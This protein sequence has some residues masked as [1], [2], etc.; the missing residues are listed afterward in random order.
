MM[1]QLENLNRLS[2]INTDQD[3]KSLS[4]AIFPGTHCPLFGVALTAAYVKNMTMIIVGTSE[5]TYYTKNFAYHRQ[6]GEDSVYSLVLNDNEIVFGGHD[7]V[8]EAVREIIAI[9]EPDAVMVV[10]TCVPELIGENY[11]SIQYVLQEEQDI[12]I[13]IVHTEHYKCNSHI[14]GMSRALKAL[15][16]AMEQPTERTGVNLLGHRQANVEQTELV[17]LLKKQNIE[18]KTVIPSKCTIQEIKQA[19]NVQLNIVTDMVALP[20]A[21]EMKAQ[22]NVDYIYF[23]KHMNKEKINELYRQVQSK[24]NINLENELNVLQQTY[25]TLYEQVKLRLINKTMIYGNTPMMAFETVDFLNDLGIKPLVVQIRELYEQDISNQQ[26]LLEKGHD[27]YITRIANIA[28][29][30]QLY[31]TIGANLYVGHESPILLKQKNMQQITFDSHAQK[32]GYELPIAMM[33]DLV[34]LYTK[35]L[36]IGMGM[37]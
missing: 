24:L 8:V 20:L 35:G 7:K 2:Q 30:R 32:I 23:D 9:E 3:I 28:P 14:P 26:S 19:A 18:I 33:R 6:K 17:Q 11:D 25:D 13:F 21:E 37:N 1:Y 36:S 34:T 5:C 4:H 15:S 10:S 27:P 12:P 22:F 16:V 31:D 29:L